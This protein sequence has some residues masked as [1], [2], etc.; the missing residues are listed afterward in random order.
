[1]KEETVKLQK[2]VEASKS[3]GAS[4]EFLATFLSRRGWPAD[5]VYA[6]LGSYWEQT[7]GLTVPERTAGG[8]SSRDAFLYLLSFST[9]ATWSSTLGS[10]LFRFIERW[11]P[12]PISHDYGYNLRNA[13]TGQMASVAVAFPIFLLV[14]RTILREAQDHPERLQSGV[15]KWLTY[16]ALLLTAGAM[17]CDLIWFFDYFLTGELTSRFVLKALTVVV[18]C[19]A[20]FIYYLGSLRWDRNTNVA[21]AKTRS[22]RF[23]IATGAAVVVS[24]CVGLGVAGT[25]SAQRQI[26]A[27]LKRVQDL[28]RIANVINIWHKRSDIEKSFAPL[29]ATLSDLRAKGL[30]PSQI[31][32]PETRIPYEYHTKSDTSYQ[33]CATFSAAKDQARGTQFWYHGKGRTCF[34]LDA[35]QPPVW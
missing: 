16:I 6:A 15:R 19:G 4:D 11:F 22:P 12:D 28:Q 5:D 13:V 18:I 33:V 14:M 23:G 26:E 31:V 21:H 10:M 7:T 17:I 1:M 30:S 27:D 9:L 2:F 34:T 8:E 32:D 24:F 3:K 29:P 20:I 35:S 25:P